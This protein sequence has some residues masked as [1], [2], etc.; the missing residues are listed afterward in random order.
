M[1]HLDQPDGADGLPLSVA[2]L[3][4]STTSAVGRTHRIAIEMDRRFKLVAGCF[5]SDPDSNATTGQSYG[6]SSERVY[7]DLNNLLR[8]EAARLDA[9]IVLT[10]TDQHAGQ[11]IQS[12]KAGIPVVC[13]KA[14]AVSSKEIAEIRMTRDSYNGFLSVTYNYLGYPMLREL[15]QMIEDGLL[16]NIQ[17]LHVEMPQEGFE[18]LTAKEQPLVPQ[19]WRLRDN[20]VPTISLDLGVHLHMMTRYLTGRRPLSV[21]ATSNSYG[22]FPQ[23]VDT[24]ICIA[25]Y[26]DNMVS[27]IWFTKTAL[28]ERNGLQVRVLGDRG[29]AKWIQENP[30]NLFFADNY[31]NKRII[32][33]ASP[34]LVV[35]NQARYTRF[36]AGH[37]SGF[38]EAFANYYFDVADAIIMHRSGSMNPGRPECFGLEE[39]QEGLALLEAI[40]ASSLSGSWETV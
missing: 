32:D 2:F 24:V 8:N 19:D 22:N 38:I 35:A 28:G 20:F 18:R 40:A 23:I 4:G 3:G 1:P 14:L 6:V 9:I 21:V 26:T 13:E 10:P 33:R 12:L 17:Q 31:G 39:A 34:G 16:G 7:E 25:K 5:S 27:N 15:R 36:K 37:P 11:V 29:S 30:E